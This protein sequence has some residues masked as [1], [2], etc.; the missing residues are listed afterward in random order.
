MSPTQVKG[1]P[2]K[3][4]VPQTDEELNAALGAYFSLGGRLAVLKT[5][6]DGRLKKIKD[7]YAAKAKPL[8]GEKNEL[9]E[10]IQTA[11]EARRTEFT[12]DGTKSRQFAHGIVGWKLGNWKHLI[13]TSDD[14]VIAALEKAGLGEYIVV[15][16]R[17]NV[18]RLIQD[19]AKLNIA[20][21]SFEQEERFYINP[22]KAKPKKK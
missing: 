7:Q 5:R 3:H 12:A 9:A 2:T 14:E 15:E 13:S 21:L 1:L 11:S 19:R 17:L 22:P 8:E 6:L 10:G 16:K 20:G 4:H 18:Q